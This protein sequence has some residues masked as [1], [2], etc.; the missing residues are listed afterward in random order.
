MSMA[1]EIM[2]MIPQSRLDAP[3]EDINIAKLARE[4]TEWQEL[5]PFLGLTP[6]EEREIV[7]RYRDR[8]QLQKRQALR[9]WKE[10]H[11]RKATYR[12]LI[13]I[14]CEQNR[15]DLADVLKTFLL[16]P[17]RKQ[18]QSVVSSSS[19]CP[20]TC[21][22][23]NFF[24]DY[25]VDCYS[26]LPHP[27]SLQWP[28]TTTSNQTFVE[29]NLLDVPVKQND[30]NEYSPIMLK[31]LF[32]VGNSKAKR[33][34]I[35]I[36]GV[37]GAGKTTLSWYAFKEWAEGRL[38][39]DIKL[40]IHVNLSDPSIHSAT[41][42]SDLIPYPDEKMRIDIAKAITANYYGKGVCFWF[43]GCDEAPAK[44]WESFL[45]R[46]IS[47]SGGRVMLPNAHITLTSRPGTSLMTSAL[48]GKVVVTGFLSLDR[49]LQ[50]SFPDKGSQLKEALQL[51]PELYSLCHL[52]LHASILAYIYD[53]VKDDL[54]TTRTGLFYP[55]IQNVIV[56]HMLLYSPHQLPNLT[57]FPANLP[58]NIRSSF[59]KLS[60]LAFDNIIHRRKV[61]DRNTS[62]KCGLDSINDAFGFLRAFVRF[63]MCGPTEQISFTHLSFQEYLAAF[64]I[65]QLNESKQ[66]VAI[67][68]VFDQNPN[69]PVLAFYAGLTKLAVDKVRKIYFEILCRSND[70]SDIAREVRPS[71]GQERVNLARDPR[72]QLLCLMNGLYE[73]QNQH[74]FTHVNLD[75]FIKD[76]PDLLMREAFSISDNSCSKVVQ[77]FISHMHLYPTDCLSLGYF[78]RHSCSQTQEIMYLNLTYA[79]LGEIEIKALMQEMQ[80][81]A[82]SHNVHLDFNHVF[83]TSN[84]L[85]S[86]RTIF[87]PQSC[88]AGF[89]AGSIY[90][91]D[92]QL[93]LKYLIEG[94][95]SSNCK[96]LSLYFC[97]SQSLYYLILMLMCQHLTYLCLTFSSTLFT[98]PGAMHLFKEALKFSG[99]QTLNLSSCDIN[100]ES[101]L[102]LVDAV[103]HKNLPLMSLK[104]DDN[105]YT[106][107]CLT[108]FF[109]M[110]LERSQFMYL[111]VL[112]VDH[113]N[114]EQEKIVNKIKI[115]RRDNHNNLPF[116]VDSEKKLFSQNKEL[117]DEYKGY[118]SLHDVTPFQNPH[119]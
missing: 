20:P 77:I 38:F 25:L 32:T 19:H 75:Y 3:V 11:G 23:T 34:V 53:N 65:S 73:A 81:P 30:P 91:L 76:T 63:T 117:Q 95:V 22:M 61:F 33:K 114:D 37:A 18:A 68:I 24:H 100:D 119:H 87:N 52:P 67:K 80:K 109:N 1:E 98:V 78:V 15:A 84:S 17:N 103:C 96:H 106:E 12:S 5:A 102:S 46:F 94:I 50:A 49:Y 4:M 115:D 93:A 13:T 79:V 116:V 92:K 89:S 35:L 10:K 16:T 41:K 58:E 45:Y 54:P 56:R 57:V 60:K 71:A 70:T 105:E 86:L 14:L 42:L 47:G 31:S 8:L 69:S 112:S 107:D 104:I 51:K 59:E 40:L 97:T 113:Y 62:M 2:D 44:L 29:L 26:S 6:A 82:S 110:L 101:L 108:L 88:L 64:H 99:L 48:T 27:S 83:L 90:L 118:E 43:D 9:K 7:E 39:E 55:L 111:A 72:R 21:A 85:T 66:A 28:T 36:E 74:L